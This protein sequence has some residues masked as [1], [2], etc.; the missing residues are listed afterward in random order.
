MARS[1]NEIIRIENTIAIEVEQEKEKYPAICDLIDIEARDIFATGKTMRAM[2]KYC[3][4]FNH[5]GIRDVEINQNN[6]SSECP[7]YSQKED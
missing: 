6:T 5:Y 7:C 4:S 3:H 1:I 2:I